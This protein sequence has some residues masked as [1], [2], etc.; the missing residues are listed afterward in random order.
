LEQRLGGLRR[1]PRG[2]SGQQSLE[3]AAARFQVKIADRSPPPG[4]HATG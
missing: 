4:A 1:N 2:R 3:R